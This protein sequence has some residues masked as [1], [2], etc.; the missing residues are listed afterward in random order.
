MLMLSFA[1]VMCFKDFYQDIPPI[2]FR[3]REPFK[4]GGLELFPTPQSFLKRGDIN[5]NIK[6]QDEKPVLFSV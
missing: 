2:E 3:K 5:L 1:M 6:G 4:I